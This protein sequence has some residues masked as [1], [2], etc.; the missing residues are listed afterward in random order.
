[1]SSE[2]FKT[3]EIWLT[4]EDD[5][6][7]HR[8]FQTLKPIFEKYIKGEENKDRAVSLS[9]LEKDSGI[10]GRQKLEA[11]QL[12]WDTLRQLPKY[13][14]TNDKRDPLIFAAVSRARAELQ[15]YIAIFTEDIEPDYLKKYRE[16]IAKTRAKLQR[17]LDRQEAAT[18]H[19]NRFYMASFAN[20]GIVALNTVIRTKIKPYKTRPEEKQVDEAKARR[21]TLHPRLVL[22][23]KAVH[24]IYQLIEWSKTQ[25]GRTSDEELAEIQKELKTEISQLRTEDLELIF[26]Y[27][28]YPTGL[29][30]AEKQVAASWLV[31]FLHFIQDENLQTRMQNPRLRM[32]YFRLIQE[33]DLDPSKDGGGATMP[34]EVF[35]PPPAEALPSII[36]DLDEGIQDLVLEALSTFDPK[37][38]T[39]EPEID[40][41][42]TPSD[43][44]A[45]TVT[46]IRTT[47]PTLHLNK[48]DSGATVKFDDAF[49]REGGATL[50]FDEFEA[51]KN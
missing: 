46:V 16:K 34:L 12:V 4:G 19:P 20:L 5:N 23:E 17:V 36:K 39:P 48:E 1:M 47:N 11:A 35:I 7:L 38:K 22:N 43:S 42:E 13:F 3:R 15:R 24:C 44:E 31:R 32:E 25:D 40:F 6:R 30:S 33:L 2:E 37:A 27:F 18:V 9:A 51:P 50:K 8:V 14:T 21:K 10:G 29:D 41:E 45:D 28:N 26:E 49:S